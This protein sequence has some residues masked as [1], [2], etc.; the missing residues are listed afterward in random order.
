MRVPPQ[1]EQSFRQ[2][3]NAPD[4]LNWSDLDLVKELLA[5]TAPG[6]TAEL[7]HA[8]ADESTIVVMPRCGNDLVG[9]AFVLHR[10]SRGISLD[11]FRWDEYRKLGEFHFLGGALAAMRSRLVALVS[12]PAPEPGR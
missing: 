9:P 8:S 2:P 1:A 7:N 12:R 5:E 6:W 11:Q 10:T 3:I 4:Q